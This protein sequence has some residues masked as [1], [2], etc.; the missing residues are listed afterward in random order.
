MKLNR[1]MFLRPSAVLAAVLGVGLLAACGSGSSGPSDT[2]LPTGELEGPSSRQSGED[3]PL[4]DERG[5][6]TDSGGNSRR[7]VEIDVSQFR[8][9]IPRDA[10]YPYY[11]PEFIPG[12]ESPLN[13]LELVIGVEINGQ[14]KAYP[15][16]PLRSREMVNDVVGGVPVLVTW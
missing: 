16:F 10:I 14:S 7:Q 1:S 8:Q 15:I 2:A 3:N 12:R 6:G 13:V 11:D 4:A 9:L 5:T